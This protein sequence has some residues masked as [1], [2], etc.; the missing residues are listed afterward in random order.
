MYEKTIAGEH[1]AYE[2]QVTSTPTTIYD[3]LSPT[4]KADYDSLLKTGVSIQPRIDLPSKN[5]DV[6]YRVP[7]DGY[8]KPSTGNVNI[9]LTALGLDESVSQG[10]EYTCPVYFW[11]SKTW[12]S[13]TTP[14]HCI[15][16][17]FFS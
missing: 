15:I 8:I 16:R 7:I 14:T 13:N 5:E 10:N 6:R 17:I 4:D 3:L 11:P 9:R 2:V 1:R 12:L